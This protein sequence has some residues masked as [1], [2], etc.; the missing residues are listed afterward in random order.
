MEKVNFDMDVKVGS[1][2]LCGLRIRMDLFRSVG[3]ALPMEKNS[4]GDFCGRML[5]IQSNGGIS[6]SPFE[7]NKSYDKWALTFI[8][9]INEKEVKIAKRI[10]LAALTSF[11]KGETEIDADA[12]SFTAY[13]VGL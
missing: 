12:N 5:A 8:R 11:F 9:K 1:F 3:I 7:T 10:F 4:N 13:I 2:Y 6:F